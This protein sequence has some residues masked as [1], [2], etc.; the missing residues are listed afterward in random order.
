MRLYVNGQDIEYLILADLDEQ[1]AEV[2]RFEGGPEKFLSFINAFLAE[3]KM[4][5]KDV[6]E[7]AV[8][9]GPGSATALR[10]ILTN[11]NIMQSLQQIKIVKIEKNK[12]EH[13]IDTINRIRSGEGVHTENGQIILPDYQ[14]EPK[15]TSSKKDK[16]GR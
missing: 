12:D 7:L 13:D 3:R 4:T 16:L 2:S 8:V 10:S 9:T 1:K 14:S 11:L 15:I 6:D 5:N